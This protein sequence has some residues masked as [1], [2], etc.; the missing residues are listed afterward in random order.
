MPP[1][2][3]MRDAFD[4]LR[5]HQFGFMAGMRAALEG[6]LGR[7]D[8][9]HARSQADAEVGD[10]QPDAR[11]RA[12]PG[13][14]SVFRSCTRR[15]RPRPRTI[16][17]SCSARPS[18]GPTK[19]RST[20]CSAAR[21]TRNDSR[22]GGTSTDAGLEVAHPVRPRRPQV[23][24]GCLRPLAFRRH[25]CCVLADGAGGHGGG[26][27]ASQAGRAGPARRASPAARPRSAGGDPR[28]SSATNRADHRSTA[29]DTARA[30]HAQHR[31]LPGHRLHAATARLGPCR[32]F[33][34]VLVPRRPHR[35]PHAR[36]QPGAGAGR[37]WHDHAGRDAHAT[38]S[39][40]SCARRWASRPTD[41]RSA[42]DEAAG[43]VEAGDVFLL[44]TDGLWEY[45]D[46][47]VLEA[48]RCRRRASP[49]RLAAMRWSA[50]CCRRRRTSPATT[51]SAR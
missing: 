47:D 43:E 45:V 20:S 23:Q 2:R 7:F 41:S 25:L 16:S 8:P 46:D 17:T 26:D 39:A 48:A 36:P 40:A 1:A 11:P 6:V 50:A 9:A 24:R 14:G 15:S 19:P 5:A 35:R 27:I 29:T 37:R 34:A 4:D 32:R 12:R 49:Q 13:C 31:G 3:A 42:P 10:R 38:P 30:G 18:C 51:T 21:T 22:R 44:C 28:L 33:A